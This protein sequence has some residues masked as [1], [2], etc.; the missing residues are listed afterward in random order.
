MIGKAVWEDLEDK[1]KADGTE[2]HEQR[3]KL[4]K[5]LTSIIKTNADKDFLNSIELIEP[6][7]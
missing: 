2:Y 4:K 3:N 1:K 6:K 5:L 7:E